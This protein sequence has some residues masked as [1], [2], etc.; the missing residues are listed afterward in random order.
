MVPAGGAL[1]SV[2]N[3]IGDCAA[4]TLSRGLPSIGRYVE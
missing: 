3:A 2:M 1:V 4:G